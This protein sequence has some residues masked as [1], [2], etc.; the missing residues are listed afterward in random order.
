MSTGIQC[1]LILKPILRSFAMWSTSAL[2]NG[3]YLPGHPLRQAH[4]LH[5]GAQPPP[6]PLV[7][8]VNPLLA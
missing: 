5:G 4:P 8:K 7:C 3:I 2:F 6:S 1:V